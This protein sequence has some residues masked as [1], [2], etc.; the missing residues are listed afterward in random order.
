M[1]D[2]DLEITEQMGLDQKADLDNLIKACKANLQS[3]NEAKIRKAFQW[4][5]DVHSN[6]KR[7]SGDPYY[8]HPLG[9][10]MII[11]NEMPLDEISVISALIHEII[12]HSN[13]YSLKDIES[14]FGPTVSEIVDTVQK[15]HHVENHNIDKLD[16]YRRLLLSLFKDVRIILIKLADRL[17]NMRTVQYIDKDKQIRLAQETLE[18]YSP[19]AHR[20]GL[21]NIKWELEDQSFKVLHYDI[22]KQIRETVQLSRK[23][24]ELYL[25]EFIK[26]I[27]KKLDNDKFFKELCSN[28]EIKYRVKHIYSIYNKSIYRQKPV[29]ELYD[30]FAIRIIL[31]T[32]NHHLC[33]VVMS[34]I[35][36]LYETMPGTY[37]NYI[38]SPKKNGYQ[39]I[40]IAFFGA[41][42]KPVEVQIRTKKMDIISERGLAAHFKY[43]PGF[44]PAES[45][46]AED[47]VDGW[48]DQIRNIFELMRD[49]NPDRLIESVRNTLVFDEIYVFTPANEFRT[50]PKDSTAL[51]F[52]YAIHT[53]IGSH[54]IGAKVNGKVVPIDYKL[55]SG[56][57]VEILTSKSQNP[58]KHWLDIVITTKARSS[59]Q[60]YF[61]EQRKKHIDAGK[62]AWREALRL[63][64]VELSL[65]ELRKVVE[66]FN[67]TKADEFYIS[68]AEGIIH[69]DQIL[70][71]INEI[72]ELRNNHHSVNHS[73]EMKRIKINLPVRLSSCC[74]PLPNDN[75]VGEIIPG[76]E[77]L[78]HRRSC[79]VIK[80]FDKNKKSMII[81]LDWSK[82]K[83]ESYNSKLI[84]KLDN[85]S[86]INQGVSEILN[87]ISGVRFIGM[88]INS[89]GDE[90]LVVLSIVIKK[91]KDYQNLI[92]ILQKTDG[93][94]AVERF[95]TQ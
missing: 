32:D 38:A 68:L 92:T 59:I 82:V 47:E 37:K 75:L 27:K 2:V 71:V 45:V 26:P 64:P 31:D 22:Y 70:S 46:M 95:I 30:L 81:R 62:S 78:T 76:V 74:F 51:D 29:E 60:K 42:K 5:I 86:N 80:N 44:L 3:F 54:C 15:I 61:K 90:P 28:Y 93:I 73:A 69:V 56:D 52:G 87:R 88:N 94:K 23:E 13:K 43:K 8:T 7:K 1:I 84:I 63:H 9:V 11:A 79:G 14:E 24:R 41:D 67:F 34:I 21:A 55:Q 4:C 17:H 25:Q 77:I 49:Q 36:D 72:L 58:E 10:A 39:S 40:H 83:V 19:F 57:V 65:K 66:H 33:Y 50:F 35:S 20:F 12:R 18:I 53:E 85:I 89:S 6:Q 16:N 48:L 91:M